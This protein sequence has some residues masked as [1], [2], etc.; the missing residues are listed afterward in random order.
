M[1][2]GKPEFGRKG[3]GP[4]GL[5]RS[6]SI[7]KN[8]PAP[9]YHQVA[10]SLRWAIGT[11]R[12]G[13]GEMLPPIHELAASL[14][15]HYHT[16]R[17][18]YRLLA[19]AGVISSR[20]GAGSFVMRGR[21]EPLSRK[22]RQI[23]APLVTVVECNWTQATAL[24]QQTSDA[25]GHAAIPWL[26]SGAAPQTPFVLGTTFHLGA[27]RDTWPDLPGELSALPLE[28]DDAVGDVI[29]EARAETGAG[30]VL[31]IERDP[32]TACEVARD[33]SV[34]GAE[35]GDIEFEAASW[36][37]QLTATSRHPDA[38]V[39]FAPRVWDA[40][41]WRVRAHPRSLVLNYRFPPAELD[42][43]VAQLS[44]RLPLP[45]WSP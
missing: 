5:T 39:L 19:E 30:R 25:L 3:P 7:D 15:V 14:G 9:L 37:D 16:V 35:L 31:A 2:P 10:A 6:V 22:S 36:P 1:N 32:V 11:G 38:V 26:A 40:L 12:V 13:A 27:M 45:S 8:S 42:G 29:R 28:L 43:Y 33:I 21:E 34:L 17:H 23:E 20:R 24:A 41:P 18:A 44:T 4:P